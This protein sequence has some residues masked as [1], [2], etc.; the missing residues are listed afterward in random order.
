MTVGERMESWGV[1]PGDW[2]SRHANPKSKNHVFKSKWVR[3]Q[4]PLR[5][6][7]QLECHIS[8]RRPWEGHGRK[9]L[10]WRKVSLPL[11][12]F[13]REQ[14]RPFQKNLPGVRR[15]C[16]TLV[17]VGART[18][19]RSAAVK[20]CY[21]LSNARSTSW[22]P[23]FLSSTT[24]QVLFLNVPHVLEGTVEVKR[25]LIGPHKQALWQEING[26]ASSGNCKKSPQQM[27][28]LCSF[29]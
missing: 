29:F 15:C 27:R 12:N 23:S 25:T 10:L 3:E 20:K 5:C 4:P 13:S 21:C 9:V 8:G 6:S 26:V 18:G 24:W 2:C 14:M 7:G 22:S 11:E 16:P 19:C 1:M 28:V 17:N